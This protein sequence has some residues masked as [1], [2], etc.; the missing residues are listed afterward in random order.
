[1]AEP[2]VGSFHYTRTDHGRT[3][4][5]ATWRV[6]TTD[7]AIANAVRALAGGTITVTDGGFLDVQTGATAV[8]VAILDTDTACLR[9]HLRDRP[10]L[11]VFSFTARPWTLDELT[12]DGQGRPGV[13]GRGPADLVIRD[14]NVTTLTGL[15][16]RHLVPELRLRRRPGRP[17]HANPAA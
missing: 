10:T 7:E 1:M 3:T 13:G 9:F 8:R 5:L 12:R 2:T 11:G 6:T 16:V 14:V 4:A 15:H 17:T